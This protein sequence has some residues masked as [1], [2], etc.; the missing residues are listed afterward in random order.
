MAGG[1]GTRLDPFTRILPKPLIPIGDKT[2]L[3]RIMDN[4]SGYSVKDF[5]LIVNYKGEMIKSY[6]D[7]ISHSYNIHYVLEKSPLGTSGGLRLLLNSIG[8]LFLF[9][10]AI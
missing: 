2:V 10:I 4:F 1:K 5:Y 8:E 9:L 7:N 3:E 6:F